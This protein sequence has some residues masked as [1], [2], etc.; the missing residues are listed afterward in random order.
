[1]GV[2]SG[3]SDSIFRMVNAM[4][5]S[6]CWQGQY[7]RRYPQGKVNHSKKWGNTCS[8]ANRCGLLGIS[9]ESGPP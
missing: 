6:S 4:I 1:L 2:A 8:V 3:F 7:S 5:I 9:A